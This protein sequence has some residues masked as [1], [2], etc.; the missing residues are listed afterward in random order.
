MWRY[1][2]VPYLHRPR[3]PTPFQSHA[4]RPPALQRRV[5]PRLQYL[6]WHGQGPHHLFAWTSSTEMR[7]SDSCSRTLAV[8]HWI[9]RNPMLAIAPMT[10]IR[11]AT[12]NPF[13]AIGYQYSTQLSVAGSIGDKSEPMWFWSTISDGVA[14]RVPA[15]YL[16]A[17][18]VA[19][20]R[21]RP[22]RPPNSTQRA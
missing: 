2:P 3:A 15:S 22:W 16:P 9:N 11:P 20:K 4:L 14:K 10:V 1:A 19:A 8:R 18:R 5:H 21:R 6:L 17:P 12:N 13:Q 7:Q